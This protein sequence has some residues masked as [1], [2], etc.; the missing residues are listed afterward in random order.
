M[1]PNALKF[2]L[3]GE[4]LKRP[5]EDGFSFFA[6]I[7]LRMNGDILRKTVEFGADCLMISKALQ[8]VFLSE[9]K[10]LSH[11]QTVDPSSM[12]SSIF[13]VCVVYPMDEETLR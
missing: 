13:C 1:P 11:R 6:L 9:P 7:L 5:F 10:K 3:S 4:Q 8:R 2:S 12:R